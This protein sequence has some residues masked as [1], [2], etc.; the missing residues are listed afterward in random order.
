MSQLNTAPEI[1]P[2]QQVNLP[3]QK[4]L[5][6]D[7]AVDQTF[8]IDDIRRKIDN[9]TFLIP[10]MDYVKLTQKNRVIKNI[11]WRLAGGSFIIDSLPLTFNA[12]RPLFPVGLDFNTFINFDKIQFSLKPTTNAYVQGLMCVAFLPEG[13]NTTVDGVNV[14]NNAHHVWQIPKKFFV[15][16]NASN[17]YNFQIPINFPFNFFH[18]GDTTAGTTSGALS[19]YMSNY[20]FGTLFFFEIVHLTT[21]TAITSFN[22]S[23]SAQLVGAQF[24]GLKFNT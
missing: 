18:Q 11:T 17:E 7:T 24:N 13:G 8:T 19:T 5:V 14:T 4:M 9:N 23:L 22:Y 6:K 21:K 1:N 3:N 20:R 10:Q 12:I 2:T 16:P 15:S